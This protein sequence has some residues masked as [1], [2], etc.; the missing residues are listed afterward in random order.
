[1]AH[2]RYGNANTMFWLYLSASKLG[3]KLKWKGCVPNFKKWGIN[4]VEL[5]SSVLIGA[6]TTKTMFLCCSVAQELIY[7]NRGLRRLPVLQ[8]K[9]GN[10]YES[11]NGIEV[12]EGPACWYKCVFFPDIE[13]PR[14]TGCEFNHSPCKLHPQHAPRKCRAASCQVGGGEEIYSDWVI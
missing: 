1:M 12:K 6:G 10:I 7:C 4:N 9:V 13:Q 5:I 3:F 11:N 2:N 8:R 14:E